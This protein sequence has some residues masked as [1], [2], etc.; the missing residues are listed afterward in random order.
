MPSEDIVIATFPEPG[1]AREGMAELRR[2]HNTGALRVRT[3]AVVER[4]SDGSWQFERGAQH[5]TFS[6]AVAGS[7]VGALLGV[8]TGPVT[9]LLSATGGLVVGEV[10]DIVEDETRQL[11]LEAMV[12]RVPPGTTAIV[13]DVEAEAGDA[14]EAA[15]DKL[16]AQLQRWPR[17]E[18]VAELEATDEAAEA[19][20]RE[21]RRIFRR[22]LAAK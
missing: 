7:V 10:F 15:M 20:R 5:P 8:L 18:V 6:G 13:A 12:G 17:A 22:R 11:I 14:L 16:G 9:A 19:G 2:L 3:A 4:R 21:M 1:A